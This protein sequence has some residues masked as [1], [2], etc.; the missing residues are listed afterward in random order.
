MKKLFLFIYFLTLNVWANNYDIAIKKAQDEG[1]KLLVELVM[2]SCPYCEKV[3]RFVLA[4]Q[5]VKETIE[6]HFIFIVLDIQKDSIPDHLT[7]RL[8]PTFYFLN[9]NNETILFEIKGAP[10]KSEF[11]N[12]LKKVISDK[13]K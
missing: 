11:L 8:T 3:E 4:N 7:S 1:K 13:D 9:P 6:N 5:E 12:F 10:S 2:E